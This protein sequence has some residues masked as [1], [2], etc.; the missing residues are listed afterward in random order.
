LLRAI[1]CHIFLVMLLPLLILIVMPLPMLTILPLLILVSLIFLLPGSVGHPKG[2][3]NSATKS[4]ERIELAT[5]EAAEVLK[6]TSKKGS[7]PKTHLN[8]GLLDEFIEKTKIKHGLDENDIICKKTV[9]Q[10]VKRGRMSGNVGQKS[11]LD[12]H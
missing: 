4:L 5:K 2:T 3:N 1:Y 11:P 7:V 6:N 9:R 10:R 12:D 8:K